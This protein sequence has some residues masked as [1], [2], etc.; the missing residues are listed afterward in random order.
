LRGKLGLSQGNAI[1]STKIQE[2]CGILETYREDV[3]G[4]S[5]EARAERG[6][7][8]L[9]LG[10]PAVG[11]EDELALSSEEGKPKVQSATQ[12]RALRMQRGGDRQV[13]G[14]AGHGRPQDNGLAR[15]QDDPHFRPPFRRGPRQI[16]KGLGRGF[17]HASGTIHEKHHP[18]PLL[19][20]GDLRLPQG[21]N[22]EEEGE[23][24]AKEPAFPKDA[25]KKNP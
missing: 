5:G 6:G 4:D 11:N 13:L 3:D 8:E 10:I 18:F 22:E 2:Q 23:G 17:P 1:W 12:V 16:Q 19:A 24:A 20:K 9:S 7:P 21:E 25:P 14:E 15:K